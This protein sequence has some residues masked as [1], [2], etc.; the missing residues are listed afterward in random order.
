MENKIER[1]SQPTESRID[2]NWKL[3]QDNLPSHTCFMV[4]DNGIA[5]VPFTGPIW[6]GGFSP[7]PRVVTVFKGHR[8]RTI[9]EVKAAST[10]CS[11][12]GPMEKF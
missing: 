7:V 1:K 2:V 9:A 8:N 6:S 3:Y 10:R 5:K 11:K 4:N 12:K